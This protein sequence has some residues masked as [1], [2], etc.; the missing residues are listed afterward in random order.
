[1]SSGRLHHTS[2]VTLV[3]LRAAKAAMTTLVASEAAVGNRPLY[4]P[5]ELGS[6]EVRPMQGYAFKLSASFLKLFPQ[7]A[8]AR[9]FD[10]VVANPPFVSPTSRNPPWSRDELI[11]ALDVYVRFK[12]NP[13]GKRS[14]EILE[15]SRIVNSIW[16]SDRSGRREDF[17][18]TNGV[19]MKL[20][21]FRRFDPAYQ[22]QGKAGLKRGN[23]LEEEVW[24]DFASDP[25]RLAMIAAAIKANLESATFDTS[26]P[27]DAEEAEEG[28]VLTRAHQV[29]ERSRKLVEA[30]KSASRKSYGKLA[31]PYVRLR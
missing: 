1:M 21:N 2:P 10:V 14:Q 4:F 25:E 30:E 24:A 11:L 3:Q 16:G 6:R 26:E 20:M 29:R 9:P 15:L 5:F 23:K 28:R 13:P 18:N 22:K 8:G 17:R 12:G 27:E 19:Y 31:R 7:L